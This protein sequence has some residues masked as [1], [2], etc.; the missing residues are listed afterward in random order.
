MTSAVADAVD[1]QS[2]A[3]NE[4]A[5][6]IVETARATNLM[7]QR[8]QDVRQAATNSLEQADV[9]Q[10]AAA[11]LEAEMTELRRTVIQSVRTSTDSVNRR[12]SERFSLDQGGTLRLSG[13]L[14]CAV[15]VVNL[16]C[17]GALLTGTARLEPDARGTL[18]V[19]G[20]EVPLRVGVRRGKDQ[21]SVVFTPDD[22]LRSRIEDL[23]ARE[24]RSDG[25][26]SSLAA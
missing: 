15:R 4:I 16:S 2:A 11:R 14:P 1:E 5:R 8:V 21:F 22:A 7:A 9:S 10:N 26:P 25:T 3:T 17:G 6:V 20:L 23:L 19:G 24:R 12:V 18:S 13:Q